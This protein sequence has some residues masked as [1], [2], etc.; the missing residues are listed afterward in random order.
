M[1]RTVKCPAHLFDRRRKLDLGESIEHVTLGI[2][3]PI[4]AGY[5]DKK[6]FIKAF[7][8]RNHLGEECA[9]TE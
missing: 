9:S 2:V 7:E 8:M 3:W 1:V 4:V 6:Y 5:I